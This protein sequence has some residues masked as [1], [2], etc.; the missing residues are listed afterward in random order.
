MTA[1]SETPMLH[2][3]DADYTPQY[4]KLARVLRD[5][6]ESGVYQC[7]E[8]LPAADVAHE[9]GASVGVTWKALAMLA[10]NRY[11]DLPGDF[12]SYRVIWSPT[13]NADS[14][15]SVLGDARHQHLAIPAVSTVMAVPPAR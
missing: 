15:A 10:A 9:Y 2:D 11:L 4:I 5:K 1:I 13:T 3:I 8:D 14:P 7:G 12:K 6:I